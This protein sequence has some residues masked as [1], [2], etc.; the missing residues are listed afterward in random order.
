METYSSTLCRVSKRNFSKLIIPRNLFWVLAG[1]ISWSLRFKFLVKS[2]LTWATDK[3]ACSWRQRRK[4]Q[5][6]RVRK[7]LADTSK[8]HRGRH[9]SRL[10]HQTQILRPRHH[11]CRH[12]RPRR[13]P[14]NKYKFWFSGCTDTL[15]TPAIDSCEWRS[16]SPWPR[17]KLA[18]MLNYKLQI[19]L[20]VKG[21]GGVRKGEN[22]N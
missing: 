6:R 13:A 12:W 11:P 19:I 3:Q 8:V 5:R 9:C 21:V 7:Q 1:I 17:H 16:L 22:E 18:Q 15:V 4:R 10:W 20:S 14:M 2:L